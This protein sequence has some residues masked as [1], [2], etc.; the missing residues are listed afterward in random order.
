M[1]KKICFVVM[2]FGKKMDYENSK[3]VD[4]DKIYKK[5]IKG[6]FE[7]EL[8]DYE[9]IRADEIAGSSIIDV[10]MYTLLMKS[11]LVIADITTLNPNAIYE[12]G[13]RHALKPY[14]TIIMVEEQCRIP[15]DL[16]HSRLLVYKEIGENLDDKEAQVIRKKL[17]EFV[18]AS[19]K[20]ET[21]S[22]LYTYLPHISPPDITDDEY[23]KIV[24][25][26]KGKSENISSLVEQAENLKNQNQFECAI[27]IWERLVDL[28]PNNCYIVQQ[29]ALC[30]YKAKV[31]NETFALDRALD[32][33]K[34]LTP[35]NSL[36]IETIGITG[37]I[38]KRLYRLNQNFDYLDEAIY[39]YKKGYIIQKDYYNGEN[40]ANCLLLKTKQNNLSN[41]ETIYLKFESK[42]VRKEIIRIIKSNL[43]AE[44][45][46]FWMYATL[47]VCYF[48]LGDDENYKKYQD[49]FY[50]SCSADWEK[51]TYIDTI[52]ELK[53]LI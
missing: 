6:L 2:G 53:N 49:E 41:E 18:T 47:S 7:K 17:K 39:F 44:E 12:L 1:S 35:K 3:E 42:N 27:P 29:L 37:A 9:L 34:R 13:V 38:Y 8:T 23:S 14:S 45:V 31:P 28:L 24:D 46:N 43:K 50:K 30:T 51:Q 40:Y 32:I 21:D 33:I 11:D 20:K 25:E 19:E 26:A 5:V 16:S 52:D 4:L 22:P 15:F 48:C 10:S 36:D